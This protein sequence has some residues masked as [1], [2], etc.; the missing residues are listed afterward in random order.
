MAWEFIY[1]DPDS[2]YALGMKQLQLAKEKKSKVYESKALNMIGASFQVRGNYVKAIDSY[3]K[4]LKLYEELGDTKGIA[5]AMGNIGSLYIELKEYKKALGYQMRCLKLVQETGNLDGVAAALNNISIIHTELKDYDQAISYA[6][7]SIE[8][9]D[10]VKDDYGIASANANIGNLY[11]ERKMYEKALPFQL[12]SLETAKKNGYSQLAITTGAEIG[13]CYH[14]LKKTDLAL[15]YL[16]EAEKLAEKEQEPSSKMMV[17]QFLSQLLQDKGNYKEAFKYYE[18]AQRLRD[19]LYRGDVQKELTQKELQAEFDK[20]VAADSL[21]NAEE[22]KVMDAMLIAKNSQI[23]KDRIQKIALYGGLI[24]LV[25]GGAVMYNRFRIIRKQKEIIEIKNKETE[26]QKVIIEEKQKEIL[27]SIS[28]AKRLQ[29]A[30]L[31]PR[32][33][34]A[35]QLPQFF[36]MYRPK[37]IVAGDFYWIDVVNKD[38]LL[39]A[40]ADCTGHGVP[41]ALV[42]VVCSNALHRTVKEF[43][44]T[45][46]GKIL[47]K[48]RELVVETFERSENEVKDGMDISLC[49]LDKKTLQIKWAGANNPL[50]IVRDGNI[51]EFKPNKQPI[52]KVDKAS[53][54]DTHDI[55][56]QS[57]DSIYIFTDGYADQFGGPNGKKFKYHQLVELMQSVGNLPV[58]EQQSRIEKEF[59]DWK[60]DL[61]QVD[62][63]CVIGIK[64]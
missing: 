17:A 23:E 1:N 2:S 4:C 5:S 22:K 64:V 57:G 28:Y 11:I 42:S 41:G 19:S 31:P 32:G 30:I 39:I 24:I 55:K 52:G 6:E 9:Y 15:K 61:E 47:D 12:K 53:L 46:P 43:A 37:D 45:E 56:L 27:A 16:R 40:A 38:T 36:I 60:G 44:I 48:T 21:R 8:M 25:L 14:Q 59:E 20:K 3:Q 18:V 58:K 26:E 33:L 62:D 51:I 54:Y 34:I 10:L 63:V 49:L 50:W 35:E 13:H 29:E 7:K